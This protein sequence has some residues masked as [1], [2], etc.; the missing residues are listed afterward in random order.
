VKIMD[1]TLYYSPNKM[2]SY[3]RILNFVIGARG[4]GK[5]YAWKV[6][7]IKRFLKYGEQFIY[8]RRYKPELKKVNQYFDNVKEEF[9]GIELK[10]K[11]REFYV[12]GKLAGWAIP[13]SSW[14]SEKSNAYPNVSTIIFDEFLREKDNSGYMP[15]EVSALLNLMDTVFRDRE[16]CRCVAL[17][18]AVS[19]VNPYFL[20]FNLIPNINKRF[21]ANESILIE[22]PDSKDFSEER[23]KTRFGKL[24][25]GT[26]YGEMSLD[27]D[28]V[29]DS[30]VFI[31]KRS[32]ESKYVFTVVYKGMNMG[33][34]VDNDL[35]LLFLSHD[36]DPS[37][38]KVFALSKEDLTE[39]VMLISGWKKNY[40]L[41]KLVG[42]FMAGYLRF[43]NQVLRTTGY[44]LFKKLSVQ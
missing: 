17:S 11:G 29:N 40:Y 14:Q 8:L 34:W 1:K 27:N 9:P 16:N 37:S 43:D 13:L 39:N 2:L 20:Y 24:I 22:I 12:N 5:S 36:H 44:E 7:P 18:N 30:N 41:K 15:N 31:E 42:S 25:D 32:K 10:V 3:N 21:N 6:H 33:V 4:I 19:V 35:G 23:R 28:F 26:N 38:K